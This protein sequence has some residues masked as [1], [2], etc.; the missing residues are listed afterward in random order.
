M[1]WSDYKYFNKD[2]FAGDA[3]L[4]HPMLIK[5]LD[6]ARGILGERVYPSP[7]LGSLA[8]FGGSSGSQHYVGENEKHIVRRATAVDVFVEGIPYQ[9]F[10]TLLTSGLFNGIGV[11]PDNT[12]PG[13]K[14]WPMLHLDIRER[15]YVGQPLIWLGIKGIDPKKGRIKT[16][17]RYPQRDNRYWELFT[18]KKLFQQYEK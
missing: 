13:G 12:G 6:L 1:D 15:G 18:N 10:I 16:F 14:K 8:R 9:N 4:A 17:Y 7:V 2:E 11:Y 5:K 3:D